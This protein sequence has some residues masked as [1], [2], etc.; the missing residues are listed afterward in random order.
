LNSKSFFYLILFSLVISCG[1]K[2]PP[3]SPKGRN[4]P[5]IINNYPDVHLPNANEIDEAQK[6]MRRSE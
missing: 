6:K 4:I 5:S 1:V 2:G 3:V